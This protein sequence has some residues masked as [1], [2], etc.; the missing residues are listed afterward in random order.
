MTP[1]P[2]RPNDGIDPDADLAELPKDELAED[3]VLDELDRANLTPQQRA[4]LEARLQQL[5]QRED[6]LVQE[7]TEDGIRR[8]LQR[9]DLTAEDRQQFEQALERLKAQGQ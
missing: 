4:E 1:S 3:K 2:Q 7:D 8:A 6:T 5:E 9:T